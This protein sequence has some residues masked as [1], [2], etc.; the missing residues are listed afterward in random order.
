[1]CFIAVSRIRESIHPKYKEYYIILH[2]Y[3]C[4][5]LSTKFTSL[6]VLCVLHD[7]CGHCCGH[8]CGYRFGRVWF[9]FALPYH[10]A[11]I[12]PWVGGGGG[13]GGILFPRMRSLH[14]GARR[15]WNHT[16][17]PCGG[18]TSLMNRCACAL[19]VF[20]YSCA[21]HVYVCVYVTVCVCLVSVSA[22]ACR[23]RCNLWAFLCV[24]YC[25]LVMHGGLSAH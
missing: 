13:G 17:V 7:C 15:L 22:R 24:H 3:L 6:P 20:A 25:I 11:W 14:T 18:N 5:C 9:G 2:G 4:V 1:M 12:P 10:L 23:C 21:F 16:R 19:H 8:C